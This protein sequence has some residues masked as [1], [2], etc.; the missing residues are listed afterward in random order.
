M[1]RVAAP[2]LKNECEHDEK[3][4]ADYQVCNTKAPAITLAN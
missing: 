4:Y 3:Q 1:L 2:P